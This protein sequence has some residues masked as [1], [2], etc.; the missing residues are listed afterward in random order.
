MTK[1][2]SNSSTTKAAGSGVLSP[3]NPVKSGNHSRDDYP[4]NS[5]PSRRLCPPENVVLLFACFT[6][7]FCKPFLYIASRHV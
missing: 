3:E 5:H 4:S 7:L 1:Q 2:A 6:G